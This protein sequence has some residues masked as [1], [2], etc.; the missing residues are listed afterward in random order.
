MR[1][2]KIALKPIPA[3]SFQMG[4]SDHSDEQPIHAVT[5]SAFQMSAY[6]ITQGQYKAVMGTNPSSFKGDDNLPVEQVSWWDARKFC[7]AVSDSSGFG[8]CYYDESTDACDFTKNGFR[9]PTEAEW[10]YACRAGTTTMYYTGDNVSDLDRAGWYCYNSS[11]KTHLVGQKTPNTWGLYDM[12]GNVWEWCSDWYGSY[13]SG[14]VTNPTGALYGAGR[15]IRGGSWN[16]YG[17]GDVCRSAVRG[18]SFPDYWTLDIGFRVV[19]RP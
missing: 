11:N 14:S 18:V 1:A 7:N 12:H 9:L 10:E 5:L 17:Y 2:L 19:R 4:S 8:R 16:G 13:T 3:G 6:E 15:V